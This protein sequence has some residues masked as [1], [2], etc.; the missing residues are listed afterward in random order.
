MVNEDIVEGTVVETVSAFVFSLYLFV[1]WQARAV[2]I[3]HG[4]NAELRYTFVDFDDASP[5]LINH[6]TGEI[7]TVST[8]DW[9]SQS[10]YIIQVS[11][12]C[13]YIHT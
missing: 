5:F 2:D 3:D 6:T 4:T 10:S 7:F 9:E 1:T 8:L 13:A 12:Q 11:K